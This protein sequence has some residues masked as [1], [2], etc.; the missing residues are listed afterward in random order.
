[1][2]EM[3]RTAGIKSEWLKNFIREHDEKLYIVQI[4]TIAG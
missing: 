3:L 2:S 4:I 1:M